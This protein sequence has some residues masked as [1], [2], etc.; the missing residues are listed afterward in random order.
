MGAAMTAP[1][2]STPDS[3]PAANAGLLT[4]GLSA[5]AGGLCVPNMEQDMSSATKGEE[6]QSGAS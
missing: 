4:I 6:G 3:W 1:A 5:A 2:L